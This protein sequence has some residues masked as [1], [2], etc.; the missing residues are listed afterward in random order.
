MKI[1]T[2]ALS[3]IAEIRNYLSVQGR[4]SKLQL[5]NSMAHHGSGE[6]GRGRP[7]KRPR[8]AGSPGAAGKAGQRVKWENL[9]TAGGWK[10]QPGAAETDGTGLKG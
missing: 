10:T 4:L 6:Q 9:E 8:P 5:I 7:A 1:T 3:I 2:S